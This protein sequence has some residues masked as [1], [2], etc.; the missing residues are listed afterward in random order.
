MIS[1]QQKKYPTLKYL[2]QKEN[3]NTW[4]YFQYM[5]SKTFMIDWFVV[6]VGSYNLENWSSDRSQEAVLICQDKK[7][8][9]ELEYQFILNKVNST[10]V[11]PDQY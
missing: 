5:D 9:K 6:S 4:M 7:L 11:L 8:A 3:I 10:P 1:K 2:Q